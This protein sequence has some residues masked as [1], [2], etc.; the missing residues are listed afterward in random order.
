MVYIIGIIIFLIEI[1]ILKHTTCINFRRISGPYRLSR[2]EKVQTKLSLK[3]KYIILL[4]IGNIGN[5][6]FIT[7]VLFLY[8]YICKANDRNTKWRIRSPTIIKLNRFLNKQI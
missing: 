5:L 4:I 6:C 3:L 2:V 1:Y 7:G 8:L